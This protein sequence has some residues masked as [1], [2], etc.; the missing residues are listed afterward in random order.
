MHASACAKG[1]TVKAW[2]VTDSE[3]YEDTGSVLVYAETRERALEMGAMFFGI[4]AKDASA[5]RAKYAD[6]AATEGIEKDARTLRKLGWREEESKIC[7]A[8]N[9]ASYDDIPESAVCDDCENCGECGHATGE[10]DD[11][12]PCGR[13][14]P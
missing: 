11:G 1:I 14:A 2:S 3:Y 6:G 10:H 7:A 13:V 4:L 12:E 9:L 5:T 8:C